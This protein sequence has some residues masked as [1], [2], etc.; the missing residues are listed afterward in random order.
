M[1]HNSFY[2]VNSEIDSDFCE[3]RNSG[4]HVSLGDMIHQFTAAE[5]T[6][7]RDLLFYLLLGREA[8]ICILHQR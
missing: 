6:I 3:F 5:L 8:A 1:P 4:I 7:M 2:E